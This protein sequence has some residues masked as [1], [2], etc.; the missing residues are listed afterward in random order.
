MFVVESQKVSLTTKRDETRKHGSF[1]TVPD[2]KIWENCNAPE[3]QFSLPSR[4]IMARF[5][6]DPLHPE[7][8]L[9]SFTLQSEREQLLLQHAQPGS[10]VSRTLVKLR[11]AL[12]GKCN[13]DGKWSP[14]IVIPLEPRGDEGT[15]RSKITAHSPI[16]SPPLIKTVG[17]PSIPHFSLFANPPSPERYWMVL[18]VPAPRG[19]Q[20]VT[21]TNTLSSVEDIYTNSLGTGSNTAA[22][23]LAGEYESWTRHQAVFRRAL[24]RKQ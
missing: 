13:P 9:R 17:S 11:T 22:S 8:L 23:P 1:R 21:L 20:F 4:R 6:P 12:A 15:E 14:Q 3:L 7:H 18:K 5:P 24:R 10:A 2:A 19:E 16:A